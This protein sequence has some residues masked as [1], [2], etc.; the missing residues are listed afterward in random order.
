LSVDVKTAAADARVVQAT[1]RG[2]EQWFALLDE[3]GS[4]DKSPKDIA[5]AL[6]ASDVPTGWA[7]TI[8]VEYARHRTPSGWPIGH[9]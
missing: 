3:A 4:R 1:G 2:F 7:Q 8:T 6:T 5:A 9:R